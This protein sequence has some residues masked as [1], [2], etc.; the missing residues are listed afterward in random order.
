M[1]LFLATDDD[2]AVESLFPIGAATNMTFHV[3]ANAESSSTKDTDDNWEEYEI[4]G[5]SFDI[6]SDALVLTD[7][8]EALNIDQLFGSSMNAEDDYAFRIS[9]ATGDNQRTPDALLCSGIAV[10]SSVQ[11]TAQN[12]Q[13]STISISLTG[14]S[15]LTIGS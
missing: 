14:N 1:R 2:P 7:D 10:I 15:D 3:A 5:L 6:S 11:V 8:G 4:T 12:R 13:N 9:T